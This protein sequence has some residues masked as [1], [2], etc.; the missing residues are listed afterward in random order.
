MAYLTKDKTGLV[1]LWNNKPEWSIEGECFYARKVPNEVNEIG[2]DVTENKYFR[3]LFL[4][5][6]EPCIAEIFIKYDIL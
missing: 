2:I 6:E 5:E 4:L 1:Q 3:E